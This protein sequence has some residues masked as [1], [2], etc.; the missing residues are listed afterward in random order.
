[1]FDFGLVL[2]VAAA[3]GVGSVLRLFAG[4]WS[5]WLP[6]G[7][8]LANTVAAVIFLL[9]MSN[10]NDSNLIV[11]AG[12]CGGLSTF[13]AVVADAGDYL[14]GRNYLKASFNLLANL[15]VPV[16]ACLLSAAAFALLLN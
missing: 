11:T 12:I 2:A 3:G 10:N 9:F 7:V 5:G 16:G 1:M 15:V 6:W 4:R 13:S 14:R 8:L